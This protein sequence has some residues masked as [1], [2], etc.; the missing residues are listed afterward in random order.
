MSAAP[1]SNPNAEPPVMYRTTV[2][3]D[4][5]PLDHVPVDY[6]EDTSGRP[7]K[8][9]LCERVFSQNIWFQYGRPFC[10]GCYSK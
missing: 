10:I 9:T 4:G 1:N 5:K 3:N 2:D 6:A 7:F 8:C